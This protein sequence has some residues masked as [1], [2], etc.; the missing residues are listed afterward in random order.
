[1]SEKII[2]D[3]YDVKFIYVTKYSKFTLEDLCKVWAERG[4]IREDHPDIPMHMVNHFFPLL[5]KIHADRIEHVIYEIMRHAD[6]NGFRYKI[7]KQNDGTDH[8]G[9]WQA[10]LMEIANQFSITESI[11][12]PGYVKKLRY[13]GYNVPV[14][15]KEY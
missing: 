5:L 6:P 14:D 12:L 3:N 8:P 9:Y 15:W 1:M 11:R 7:F 10:F 4:G 2:L 13:M